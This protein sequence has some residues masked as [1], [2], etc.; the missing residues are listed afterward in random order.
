MEMN[1]ADLVAIKALLALSFNLLT[2]DIDFGKLME[3]YSTVLNTPE[4]PKEMYK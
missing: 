1:E 4:K 2:D 3:A